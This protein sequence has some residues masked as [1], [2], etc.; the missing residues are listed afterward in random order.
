MTTRLTLALLFIVPA[1][2]SYPWSTTRDRVDTRCRRRGRVWSCSPG[3]VGHSSPPWS[4][5]GCVGGETAPVPDA[6]RHCRA[7][8]RCCGSNRIG[9]SASAVAAIAGYR[10]RYGLRAD[11]VRIRT[12]DAGT[13]RTTWI[14]LTVDAADNLA[15]LQAASADI[16]LD[17]TA[18][19][20]IRRLRDHLQEPGFTTTVVDPA[21]VPS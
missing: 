19:I 8:R 14:G 11:S 2:L 15:A 18:E 17:K 7:R 3:G 5:D 4:R 13:R 10:D 1:A 16:P 21:D 9:E 6:R 12:R 20:A